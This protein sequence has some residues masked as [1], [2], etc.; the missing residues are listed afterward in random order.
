MARLGIQGLCCDKTTELGEDEVYMIVAARA[1]DGRTWGF[2]L[3]D[4]SGHWDMND[5]QDDSNHCISNVTIWDAPLPDGQDVTISVAIMEEDGGTSRPYTDIAA[6]MLQTSGDPVGMLTG[7]ILGVI[8]HFFP[9]GNSD[10][11]IGAF[12]VMISNVD[13]TLQVA[14]RPKDCVTSEIVNIH[15]AN[16]HEFRMNGDGSNYVGW[17]QVT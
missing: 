5:G 13:N 2:R 9:L 11:F 3:P 6:A 16:T 17:Y 8:G 10:D 4:S 1:S 7:Q 14:W 15:G 12:S